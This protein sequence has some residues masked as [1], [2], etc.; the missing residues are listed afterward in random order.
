MEKNNKSAGRIVPVILAGGSG[1]RLWPLSR[2]LQPKQFLPLMEDDSLLIGA[3]AVY[4]LQNT[5]EVP[6][7]LIEIQ[8]TANSRD[9]Q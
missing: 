9:L 7:Q 6:L 3:G 1:S 8:T 2:A 4:Q 5:A